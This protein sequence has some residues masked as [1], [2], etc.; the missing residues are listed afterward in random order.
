MSA[1]VRR[2][3]PTPR[4]RAC[5]GLLLTAPLII[6]FAVAFLAPLEASLSMSFHG[7]DTSGI[8]SSDWTV[9][10][11]A[12]LGNVYYLGILARTLRIGVEV[13]IISVILAYPI[14]LFIAKARRPVQTLMVFVYVAPWFVN[15]AV[16]ALGWTFL[17]SPHGMVNLALMHLGLIQAPL[18]LMNNE[19]GV[20]I[21]LVH[22]SL[23]LLVLP[24]NAA[25]QA[26]E[27]S[28]IAAAQNLGARRWEVFWRIV[29]P[30]TIPGLAVGIVIVFLLTITAYATPTLLGGVSTPMV[31]FLTYQINLVKL[32]WPLGSAMAVGF[33]A[34]TLV[35]VGGLQLA[36]RSMT[37]WNKS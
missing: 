15:V 25:I 4:C 1:I 28:L 22:V 19:T 31:A 20:I 13:T 14:A 23:V 16:K 17:L 32:D 36:V 10:N 37:K 24:L 5:A 35:T 7:Q 18:R 33:L 26:I 34:V 2:G 8:A 29:F 11:Y 3:L 27:P 12:A 6:L 9:R 30:L 21:G